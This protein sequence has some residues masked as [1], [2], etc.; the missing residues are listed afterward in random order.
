LAVTLQVMLADGRPP[1][2]ASAGVSNGGP[3]T[4]VLTTFVPFTAMRTSYDVA[5]VT[6][7]QLKVRGGSVGPRVMGPLP[8]NGSVI[9]GAA[10]GHVAAPGVN[11]RVSDTTRHAP[12]RT[13]TLQVAPAGGRRSVALVLVVGMTVL[14]T[15]RTY[16]SAPVTGFHEKVTGFATLAAPLA[17][18]PST[19]ALGHP[20]GA[21]IVKL[22]SDDR[23]GAH[24]LKVACT[25]Q[26]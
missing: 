9:C 18:A 15:V 26:K 13:A 16:P 2:R 19:G 10:D 12:D 3:E 1:N 23:A 7:D 24:V 20:A 21:L 6:V 8:P 17:G 5:F 14:P 4:V 11:E 25:D 22:R